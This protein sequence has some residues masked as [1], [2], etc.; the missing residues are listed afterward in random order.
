MHHATANYIE[1]SCHVQIT[2]IRSSWILAWSSAAGE[3]T[4]Y[5]ILVMQSQ[6]YHRGKENPG[7]TLNKRYL[8][9]QHLPLE[10]AGALFIF[11]PFLCT[12]CLCSPLSHTHTQPSTHLGMTSNFPHTTTNGEGETSPRGQREKATFTNIFVAIF[13]PCHRIPFYFSPNLCLSPGL[14]G[15]HRGGRMEARVTGYSYFAESLD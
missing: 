13:S 2:L 1:L 10:A 4:R 8:E 11:P 5:Q 3:F 14:E 12:S 15:T 7:L 6:R 9:W